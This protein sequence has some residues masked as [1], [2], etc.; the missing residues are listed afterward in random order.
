MF[1]LGCPIIFK[2]F[3]YGFLRQEN[4]KF[5]GWMKGHG[6]LEGKE[7]GQKTWVPN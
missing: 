4:Y 6:F 2:T 3:E 5:L 1:D 7:M